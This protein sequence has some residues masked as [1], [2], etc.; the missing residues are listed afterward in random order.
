MTE[1]IRQG[2]PPGVP[3]RAQPSI[4]HAIFELAVLSF[5]YTLDKT[6]H[7][8][9]HMLLSCVHSLTCV[10]SITISLKLIS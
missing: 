5:E 6:L 9:I 8:E 7:P 4:Y 10:N 2:R 1:A 3:T